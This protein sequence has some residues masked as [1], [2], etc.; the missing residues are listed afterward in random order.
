MKIDNTG[1]NKNTAANPNMIKQTTK[2][3]VLESSDNRIKAQEA[4]RMKES[5]ETSKTLN[6]FTENKGI[7]L[8]TKA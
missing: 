6:V 3:N 4:Q 7:N 2:K 1:I 5:L 8:D